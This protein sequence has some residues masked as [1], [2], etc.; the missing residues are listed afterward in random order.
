MPAITIHVSKKHSA[1]TIRSHDIPRQQRAAQRRQSRHGRGA[2]P[3]A[4]TS[5]SCSDACSP[6]A[7][8]PGHPPCSTAS[9][10]SIAPPQSS[11]HLPKFK[12]KK[13]N[14]C[15]HCTHSVQIPTMGPDFPMRPR[16]QKNLTF[17]G[18]GEHELGGPGRGA[19]PCG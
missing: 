12:T 11:S 13:S 6:P 7:L 4:C 2:K 17:G 14:N 18:V 1:Y 10:R 15:P 3:P 9:T 5:P 8:L 19:V 16:A